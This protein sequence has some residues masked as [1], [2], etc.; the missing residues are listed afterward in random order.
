VLKVWTAPQGGEFLRETDVHLEARGWYLRDLPPGLDLRV[1]LWAVGERGARMMRAARPVRLP[2]ADPSNIWDEIYVN[3]PLGR[4]LGRGE[5]LTGGQP[6][7][8]RAGQTAAEGQP[9]AP[10]PYLGSSER[11][12][13]GPGRDIGGGSGSAGFFRQRPDKGDGK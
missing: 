1:E 4:R 5:P 2:P 12:F 3:I 13:G 8:W 9:G 10:Q 7:Q 11:L 6:L